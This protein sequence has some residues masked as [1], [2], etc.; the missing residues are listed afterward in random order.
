[1]PRIA[2]ALILV[3]ASFLLTL[4]SAACSDGSEH[5]S[6]PP[7][8]RRPTTA[9]TSATADALLSAAFGEFATSGNGYAELHHRYLGVTQP[10]PDTSSCAAWPTGA[11]GVR[12]LRLGY[13][14]EAPLHTVDT[15]GRDVGFEADLAAELVRRI[16]AHYP[17]AHVTL[18]WVPVGV[19]LPIG[20]TKN[21]TEFA[22]LAAGLR[23]GQFDVAFSSIVPI[24]A[25]DIRYLCPTMTMFPGVL[26]TGLDGL[27]VS[28]I[29]DR[30]SLVTFLA[31]HPGMTFVHGMGEVVYE[32]L[33]A[34]VAA[35]GGSIS[36]APA[37]TTPHFRMAD[38]VGLSKLGT[39]VT[40]QGTLLD[41]NPRTDVQP[42]AVFTLAG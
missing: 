22:A 20:P 23:A 14:A 15:S 4:T 13:V 16:N 32:A 31:A 29:H 35:A 17:R 33:A 25:P 11:V 40:S 8:T 41:V 38:I 6:T 26:Y 9:G 1:M 34:D 19:T 36:L 28:S 30:A 21:P 18:E 5:A 7:S 42:R 37:G 27:D 3:G 12:T 24:D 10:A 39:G 2:R